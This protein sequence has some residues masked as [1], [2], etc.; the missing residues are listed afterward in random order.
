MKRYGARIPACSIRAVVQCSA[1][2][3]FI[4]REDTLSAS[5]YSASLVR[6][7][8][9]ILRLE[10]AP[11][12]NTSRIREGCDRFSIFEGKAVTKLR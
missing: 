12:L 7:A 8:V 1:N 9:Y 6:Y 4:E 10:D 3:S 11:S 5:G 2:T